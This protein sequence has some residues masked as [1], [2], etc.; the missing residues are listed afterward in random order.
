MATTVRQEIASGR[1]FGFG[2][3]WT[4]FLSVL[5]EERVRAAEASLREMLGVGDLRGRTFL[6]VGSGSG[7]FS[8]AAR[9]LGAGVRSFDYDPDSVDCTR[10]LKRR[11]FPADADW[12]IEAGSVL[13]EAYMEGLGT[14]D[15]V[16]AWGVLHH[17]G[18]MWTALEGACRRVSPG[19]LLFVALYNDQGI[20]SRL[21]RW[22]K[23]AYCSGLPGQ[24]LVCAILIPALVVLGLL[25]DLARRRNPLRRYTRPGFRG[26]SAFY[27]WF[28]WLGGLP[29]EVAKPDEVFRF[30]CDRGFSL[31]NLTTVG[32]NLGN[33]QYVFERIRAPRESA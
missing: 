22:V 26:M 21:W 33:N 31:R 7:L 23:R 9:R 8:L 3:N 19:G 4:R 25:N 15:V 29:F 1:R 11:Y 24:A 27:N 30:C 28:D 16:Y 32:G 14:F 6:D 2:R 5:D 10:E 20:R 13:D 18:A 12:A 17:T